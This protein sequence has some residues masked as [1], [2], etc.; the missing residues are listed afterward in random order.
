M[1]DSLMLPGK[2]L[3]TRFSSAAV[4]HYTP[5]QSCLSIQPPPSL[6]PYVQ[7]GCVPS[8]ELKVKFSPLVDELAVPE[9]HFGSV[10]HAR[11]V[12]HWG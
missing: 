6:P 2:F 7:L 12:S 9:V 10:V 1:R 11:V 4:S 3:C 8:M 5:T